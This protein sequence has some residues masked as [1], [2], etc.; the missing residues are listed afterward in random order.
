MITLGTTISTTTLLQSVQQQS[1]QGARVTEL[2]WGGTKTASFE[3]SIYTI[4]F[5]NKSGNW[6][7]LLRVSEDGGKTFG[8]KMNLSNSPTSDSMDVEISADEGKVAVSWWENNETANEPVIRVSSDN[9][10]TFGPLLKL[11]SNG[12]LGG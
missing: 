11:A 3:N 12:T 2:Q 5:S 6:E 4:W 8:D 9:G 1:V 7:V 10:K